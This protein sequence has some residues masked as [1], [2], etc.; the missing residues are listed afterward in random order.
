MHFSNCDLLGNLILIYFEWG[1]ESRQRQLSRWQIV[2]A[3]KELRH[4][5]R[6]ALKITSHPIFRIGEKI[7]LDRM[8]R[9][10]NKA[11]NNVMRRIIRQLMSSN[12]SERSLRFQGN[13]AWSND[14][15]IVP[16]LIWDIL[17]GKW[18]DILQFKRW[19]T[20][21]LFELLAIPEFRSLKTEN[22][23]AQSSISCFQHL[24]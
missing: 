19:K 12:V 7:K 17:Y 15:W 16:T 6:S 10:G 21:K 13:T 23:Q 18:V 5:N 22:C 24:N 11:V 1:K 20:V 8:F 2:I 14:S 3:Q 4:S 9:S